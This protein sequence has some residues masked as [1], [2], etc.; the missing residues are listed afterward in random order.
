MQCEKCGSQVQAITKH[1]LNKDSFEIDGERWSLTDAGV[2]SLP[3]ETPAI[4]VIGF[5]FLGHA[6]V[7]ENQI[8]FCRGGRLLHY[9]A[10]FENLQSG[11]STAVEAEYVV[12][13][14]L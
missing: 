8:M 6:S 14:K 9:T 2:H 12:I 1:K 4:R 7:Y 11:E 5:M 3:N 10:I 13:E